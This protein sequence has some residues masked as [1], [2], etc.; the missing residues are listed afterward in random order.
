MSL[1]IEAS[2]LTRRFGHFTAVDGISLEVEE[3]TIFGLL[4]ANGAGKSTTIRMLCG[5]LG[6][7]S[8]EGRVGGYDIDREPEKIKQSIGYMSQEFSL[9]RDLTVEE[10]ITFFGGVYG[11]SRQR[12]RQR[13]EWVL[14]MAGLRG[15]E[16]MLADQLSGGWRQRLALGCAVLHEPRIL[17][18]DEPTGGVDPVSRREFWEL[19][20]S[21]AEQGVTVLVTTHYL[22][23]AEYCNDVSLMHAGRIAAQGSPERLKREQIPFTIWQISCDEVTDALSILQQQE[24]VRESSIFGRSLHIGAE[25]SDQE[26]ADTIRSLLTGGGIRVQGVDPIIPSLE[27]VFIHVIGRENNAQGGRRS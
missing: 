17:F 19:I 3:G 1:A 21:F 2:G 14:D 6:S 20:N 11:L 18:L 16:G 8:G 13:R 26:A 9:Y 15:R 10:N 7:S 5:L 4:G 27:D 24:W 25:L 12:I 23:E 22:D